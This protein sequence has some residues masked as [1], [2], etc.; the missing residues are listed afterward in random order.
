[1]VESKIH[2]QY[3]ETRRT[4]LGVGKMVYLICFCWTNFP[5][6]IM[7][8]DDYPEPAIDSAKHE[9]QEPR[10]GLLG[11][12]ITSTDRCYR[13]WT[14]DFDTPSTLVAYSTSW[15]LGDIMRMLHGRTPQMMPG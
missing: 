2:R 1:M 7:V 10:D 14:C 8:E 12:P 5:G 9:A 6:M 3:R 15:V 13:T 11:C 4:G